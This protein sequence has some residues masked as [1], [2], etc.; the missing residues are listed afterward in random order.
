MRK[1]S[2][3]CTFP[4][5]PG[6]AVRLGRCERHQQRDVRP[7]AGRRGYGWQWQQ[8][9]RAVLAAQPFCRS[10]GR[11]AQDVHHVDGN[12]ANMARENLAPVCHACHS[13]VT[14]RKVRTGASGNARKGGRS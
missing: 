6:V 2:S 13:R 12:P 14:M 7:N 10:C 5:C 8:L 11:L 1:L 4:G 9:R 3:A